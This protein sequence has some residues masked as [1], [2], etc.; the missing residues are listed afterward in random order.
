MI[1]Q[2]EKT[3]IQ[4]SRG[5]K[6]NH[7]PMPPTK[8][9][10]WDVAIIGSG[11]G[12]GMCALR[13]AQAGLRVVVLER[14][15][16][17]MR[18]D[19]CWDAKSI[20]LDG[21]Y[22]SKTPIQI[23]QR[24]KAEWFFPNETVGGQSVFYGA[25]SLR[26]RE[27]DFCMKSKHAGTTL[28]ALPYA[29]WPVT[30]EEME[31]YYTE[32]ERLLGVAGVAGAD[33]TEPFRLAPYQAAPPA[34]STP[35]QRIASAAT[36]LGLHPFPIP[37]AISY[38]PQAGRGACVR[39]TTCDAFPC[40][41]NAKNDIAVTILPQAM[42]LGAC[43]R[44]NTIAARILMQGKHVR[45]VQCV[46]SQ[47]GERFEISC[48]LCIVSCGAIDSPK[49]LL[50]SGLD[51]YGPNG[52]LIGK[53]L[54]R[55]CG[56]A[57]TGIFPFKTN[58]ERKFHKQV[59]LTDFYF[60]HS[61]VRRPQGHLGCI[62][63]VHVPPPEFLKDKA[64]F[65]LKTLAAITTP[66]HTNLMC[67]A[68][69]LP[70][71]ENRVEV[72]WQS[73]DVYGIPVAKVVHRFGERDLLARDALYAQARKILR[74]AGAMLTRQTHMRTFTHAVGTCR[75]GK[76]SHSSV[77]DPYCQLHG[78]PN[79][80]VVDGSIMPSSAGVNPSL[81]IA[82]NALRVADYIQ[83]RFDSIQSTRTEFFSCKRSTFAF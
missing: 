78:V 43:I 51:D 60:G 29:D 6:R 41:I 74:A 22:R 27:G 44:P 58:P 46:D 42:R 4:V 39:C 67:F 73:K 57:V 50:L 31:P 24:R 20:F 52:H 75:M 12:G 83:D 81:T 16:W 48:A 23:D 21:P 17:V 56:G 79:L 82:A 76:D 66:F 80:F 3:Y 71:I 63:D 77:L 47:T 30:Y 53:Y 11:F 19:S 7:A 54:M 68:E 26:F 40:K 28:N 25:A 32:A 14:G 2:T 64:P 8:E 69:D 55:H 15:S 10:H 18:D 45:G 38:T 5:H 62:Q 72:N 65:G 9:K 35:S 36:S 61:S 34:Y 13:L 33:P 37:L 1:A 49:L 59:C 70:A